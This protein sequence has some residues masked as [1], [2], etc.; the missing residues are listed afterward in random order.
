MIEDL[1]TIE[2]RLVG[3]SSSRKKSLTGVIGV[4]S[5][6]AVSD[7]LRTGRGLSRVDLV[8]GV[9][10]GGANVGVAVDGIGVAVAA[11]DG[12]TGVAV[13][14]WVGGPGV[15][16]AVGNGVGDAVGGTSGA[17]GG[18]VSSGLGGSFVGVGSTSTL[19]TTVASG[20]GVSAI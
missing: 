20:D 14:V 18:F 15:N 4:L 10:V 12:G 11:W 2:S 5:G 13:A 17:V 16:V 9:A 19:A 7:T 1:L 3:D 8:V 6:V